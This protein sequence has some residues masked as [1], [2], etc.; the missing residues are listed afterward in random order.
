[1]QG[2]FE[3]VA[4]H[5]HELIQRRIC[6]KIRLRSKRTA[7]SGKEPT[8]SLEHEELAMEDMRTAGK[9][10]VRNFSHLV[11]LEKFLDKSFL[12]VAVLK[13]YARQKRG[14]GWEIL[15]ITCPCG[16]LGAT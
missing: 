8:P 10:R 4:S 13:H 14:K 7:L 15:P 11:C 6:C 16:I 12:L 1:M 3:E 9:E 2:N 5:S